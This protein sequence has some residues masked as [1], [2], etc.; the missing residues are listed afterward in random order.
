MLTTVQFNYEPGLH[1][2]EIDDEFSEWRLSPEAIASKKPVA[3]VSPEP[4]FSVGGSS[5]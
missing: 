3:Q 2:N 1:A 4:V 5:A